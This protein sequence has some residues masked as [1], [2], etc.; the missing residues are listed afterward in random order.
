[1]NKQRLSTLTAISLGLCSFASFAEVTANAAVSSNYFW[2]GITQTADK[3]QVSGG[4]DYG[5]SSGFYA[6]TWASNVDF[7][8][9]SPSYELDFYTGYSGRTGDIG[10][11]VG[12]IYYAYPDA[13]GSS[14]FGEI[15]GA[16]SWHWLEG[17]LSY[18]SNAQSGATSEEDMMYL[19]L[20]ATF[21]ILNKTNLTLLL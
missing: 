5:H 11:D 8:G 18:L 1:M 15:Y 20:N 16:L 9:D 19:E 2:R 4:I 13:T 21:E 10:Y 17:K 6:G 3:A 12:Y 7:G 14:D